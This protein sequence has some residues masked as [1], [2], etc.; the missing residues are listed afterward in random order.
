MPVRKMMDQR[1]FPTPACLEGTR[2]ADD[3]LIWTLY[4]MR[5]PVSSD[6]KIDPC[7][8]SAG[9]GFFCPGPGGSILVP[10]ARAC[11]IPQQRVPRDIHSLK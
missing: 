10:Q 8:G 11:N 5:R 6:K 1:G 4:R 9:R 3:I 2:R 7:P